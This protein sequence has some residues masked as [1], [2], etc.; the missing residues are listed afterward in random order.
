MSNTTVLYDDRVSEGLDA[1][2]TGDHLWLAPADFARATGWKL[3]TQ[4]LC[5]GD[6]CVQL[7]PA[8]RNS[9][10]QLDLCAFARHMGQPVVHETAQNAYAFG[11]SAGTRHAALASGVAPDFTLPDLDGKLHSL[12]DYRGKKVFLFSWGSY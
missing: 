10:G 12:S 1:T 7:N 11:E 3:E 2:G 5:R 9:Q 6:A 4:G 8:W